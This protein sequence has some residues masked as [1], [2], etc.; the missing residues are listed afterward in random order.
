MISDCGDDLDFNS[1]WQ[2]EGNALV[3]FCE[4]LYL[5]DEFNGK[6]SDNGN[7][8]VYWGQFL[9]IDGPYLLHL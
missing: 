9:F 8:V 1:I 5:K 2:I 3:S 6:W 7:W 4:R